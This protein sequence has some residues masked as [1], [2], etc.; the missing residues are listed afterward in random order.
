MDIAV[1]NKGGRPRKNP[2]PE[3]GP[4]EVLVSKPAMPAPPDMVAGYRVKDGFSWVTI[5]PLPGEPTN[6]SFWCGPWRVGDG[7]DIWVP[8]GKHVCLPNAIVNSIKDSVVKI[9][10]DDLSDER[11]PVRRKVEFTRFPHSDP[12]PASWLEFKTFRDKQAGLTHPN[13]AAKKK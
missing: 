10:E 6:K 3:T 1:K 7:I 12:I 4:Q 8:R 9:Y 11:N 13:E 2:L 5:F